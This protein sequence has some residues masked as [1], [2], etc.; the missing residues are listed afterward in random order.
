MNDDQTRRVWERMHG[1]TA[2]RRVRR[3][4]GYRAAAERAEAELARWRDLANK[5]GARLD[6]A[7]DLIEE[8]DLTP[9]ERVEPLLREVLQ[10]VS[11]LSGS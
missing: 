7:R 1:L 2:R 8:R 9:P 11:G 3:C 4:E 6:A 10:I 5:R